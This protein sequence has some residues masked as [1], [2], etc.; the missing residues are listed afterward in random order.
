MTCQFVDNLY[1]VIRSV[2]W[3]SPLCPPT[4]SLTRKIRVLQT[5]TIV[6]IVVV[7]ALVGLSIYIAV[8]GLGA[9]PYQFAIWI[10]EIVIDSVGACFMVVLGFL[11]S[12]NFL[13]REYLSLAR[14]SG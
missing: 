4:A 3:S 9:H 8:I 5:V 2:P 11:T 6:S 1:G 10:S 13:L 14:V 7:G 12:K